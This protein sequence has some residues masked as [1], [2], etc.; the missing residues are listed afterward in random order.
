MMHSQKSRRRVHRRP[1]AEGIGFRRDVD[2]SQMR[3]SSIGWY[4]L[5]D[6]RVEFGETRA[7]V[8]N[9]VQRGLFGKRVAQAGKIRIPQKAVVRFI[10]Y[11]PAEYKLVKVKQAWLCAVLFAEILT[12]ARKREG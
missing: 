5:D 10:C 2:G 7:K 9:W 1:S 8:R 4:N 6:L 11:R 3:V 12:G